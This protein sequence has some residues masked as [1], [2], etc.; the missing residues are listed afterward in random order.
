MVNE[1][2]R[3]LLEQGAVGVNVDRLLVLYGLVAP[4]AEPRSVVEVPRSNCLREGGKEPIRLTFSP[5]T[6]QLNLY[7]RGIKHDRCEVMEMRVG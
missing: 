2:A 6:I 1:P 7:T 3:L 5:R 4:F